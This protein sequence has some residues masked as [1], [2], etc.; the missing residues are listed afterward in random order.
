MRLEDHEIHVWIINFEALKINSDYEK[1]LSHEELDRAAR[2]KFDQDRKVFIVCRYALRSLLSRYLSRPSNS[3]KFRYNDFGKPSLADHSNLNF[4]VSH[5][6]SYGMIGFCY[7]AEIGVDVEKVRPNDDLL[8]I[9]NRFFAPLECKELYAASRED[10]AELF[11]NC[12]TRKEAFVKASGEGLS[13]P[14]DRFE[15][16]TNSS[17]AYFKKIDWRDEQTSD[18]SLKSIDFDT[19]YKAA[20]ASKTKAR[21]TIVKNWEFDSLARQS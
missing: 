19:D 10:V 20:I 15:V 2:F 14:L 21:K 1:I 4:N 6:G 5:S 11:F 3:L 7:D 18:W 13:I 9:S 16:S 12:W 8:K 17:K